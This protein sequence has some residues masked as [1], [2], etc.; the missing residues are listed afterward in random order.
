MSVQEVAKCT[1]VNSFLH[2]FQTMYT[3]KNFVASFSY[4][5]SLIKSGVHRQSKSFN[6]VIERYR[7]AV[8]QNSIYLVSFNQ[9]LWSVI[10]NNYRSGIVIVPVIGVRLGD[11]KL[12]LSEG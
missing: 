2:F 7:S 9:V 8:N 6:C 3:C 12:W 4:S 1:Q 5:V 11:A 10:G